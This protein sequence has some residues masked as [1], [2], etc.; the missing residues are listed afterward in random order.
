[1]SSSIDAAGHREATTEAGGDRARHELLVDPSERHAA[2]VGLVSQCPD[3]DVRMERL[4]NSEIQERYRAFR[5]LTHF[6]E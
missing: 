6:E 1:M 3:F 4:T 5:R 2:L